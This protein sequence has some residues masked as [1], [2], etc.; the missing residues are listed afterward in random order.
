MSIKD[1]TPTSVDS[2]ARI[3]MT[4]SAKAL[5]QQKMKEENNTWEVE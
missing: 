4:L 5:R 1:H 2:T 3:L